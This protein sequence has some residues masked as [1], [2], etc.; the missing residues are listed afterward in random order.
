MTGAMPGYADSQPSMY[1]DCL[2]KYMLRYAINLA[3]LGLSV[4]P[5]VPSA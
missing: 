5:I 3:V 1:E 4:G 2:L